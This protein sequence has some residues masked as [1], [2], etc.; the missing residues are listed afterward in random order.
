[1]VAVE[2]GEQR[3]AGVCIAADGGDLSRVAVAQ[4]LQQTK[5]KQVCSNAHLP[6]EQVIVKNAHVEHNLGVQKGG[7]EPSLRPH[8]VTKQ[9]DD[10][11]KREC[12]K[13]ARSS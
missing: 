10:D 8:Q 7:P 12:I 6:H 2:V 9:G 13:G 11:L 5:S 1:M 4:E 3:P